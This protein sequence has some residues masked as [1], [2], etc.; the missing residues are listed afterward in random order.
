MTT[1]QGKEDQRSLPQTIREQL[2]EEILRGV[3]P[4]GAQLRQESLAERF[5]ASRIP[6][7]EALRQLE[8]EGLVSYQLNRGAVVMA[9]STR[10]ICELLDIRAAL[11]TYA[12]KLAVPNMV[13]ADIDVMKRILA[14]YDA[15]TSPADWAEYN[16]QFH[17]A[18]C[19]PAN[20]QRLR[21]MIEEYCLS[22]TNR[23]P[24]LR[25]SLD[26]EKGDVQ[27][28]HYEIV[29]ACKR[30]AVDDVVELIERHIL[31]TKR[32]VMAAARLAGLT[33]Q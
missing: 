21:K 2:R 12:A 30:R 6:V 19:A 32:E 11:E 29:D 25:M 16:R 4:P 28:D 31:D 18:L 3:L 26:T 24:H 27:R 1:V 14:A 22:T 8:A 23:Y 15:A 17:L 7:R 13:A 33:D 10:E 5:G 20:N 9:M